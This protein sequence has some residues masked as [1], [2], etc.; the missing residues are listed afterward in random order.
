MLDLDGNRVVQAA[1][2]PVRQNLDVASLLGHFAGS[3]SFGMM[4]LC[5]RLIALPGVVCACASTFGFILNTPHAPCKLSKQLSVLHFN[6]NYS[7]THQAYG[8]TAIRIEK[9]RACAG[10]Y[11]YTTYDGRIAVESDENGVLKEPHPSQHEH[12]G[13]GGCLAGGCVMV[14]GRLICSI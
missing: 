2:N 5:G 9:A 4:R 8:P 6:M 12:M 10:C 14:R 13:P 11:Q 7:P 3:V 1:A